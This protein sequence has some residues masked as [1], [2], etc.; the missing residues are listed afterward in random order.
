MKK[1]F[2]CQICQHEIV[3]PGEECPYCKSRSVIA[4][5]ASPRIL[6]T[7]FAVM[8][9]FFA[10]TTMLAGA[11]E[12]ERRERGRQHFESANLLMKEQDFD[13]AIEHY[14]DALLYSRTETSYQLGLANALFAAKEF[15][16]TEHRLVQLRGVDPTSGIVNYRLAQLAHRNG[17]ID[18]AVAYYRTAVY[19]R[20]DDSTE[21]TG[22]GIRVSVRLELV[23]LLEETG[24]DRELAVALQELTEIDPS[25]RDYRHRYA[26]KL[27]DIEAP[28]E[29]S[30]NYS[31][32]LDSDPRD[33]IALLGRAEAEFRLGNYLTARTHYNRAQALRID[34]AT[35]ER[36]AL[37]NR[38][39]ELDPTRR[40]ISVAERYRRSRV[41]VDR[42]R[43][44][45]IGCQNPWGDSFVGPLPPLP[46]DLRGALDAADAVLRQTRER[47]SDEKVEANILLAEQVW[48][49]SRP[50]CE[51]TGP[52]DEA[53]GLVLAKLAR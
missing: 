30:E 20:W 45:V 28:E 4:E 1:R 42:T 39:I 17:H 16:E 21:A 46:P 48:D 41:L 38:V 23:D 50:L 12:R 7:V 40:G 19:G 6:V 14:R 25:N 44:V 5:G 53:L 43:S 29:A 10:L 37:C 2:T 18:E 27:I 34:P 51:G 9:G 11:F 8:I 47:P 3:H 35:S 52:N 26:A 13:L 24:R 22:N 31:L 49:K 32:L 36:V 33:R 15:P